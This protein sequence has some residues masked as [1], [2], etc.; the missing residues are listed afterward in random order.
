M[1]VGARPFGIVVFHMDGRWDKLYAQTHLGCCV[2]VLLLLPSLL[3]VLPLSFFCK[4]IHL[5]IFLLGS[6]RL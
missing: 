6:Y 4:V 5:S 2:V 3:V 1:S